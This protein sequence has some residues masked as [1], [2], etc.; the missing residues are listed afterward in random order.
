MISED[1][2]QF[3]QSADY[4][5]QVI[6]G[7]TPVM[8]IYDEDYYT[9]DVGAI[10]QESKQPIITLASSSVPSGAKEGT[11]VTVRGIAY[12]IRNIR[13]DG[14]GVTTIDLRK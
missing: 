3:F 13:P 11:T 5:E 4:A 12:K 9:D 7:S 2:T 8:A 1:I 6:I 10:G 14:T